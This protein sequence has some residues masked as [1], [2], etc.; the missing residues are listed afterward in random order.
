MWGAARWAKRAGGSPLEFKISF[1]R[2]LEGLTDENA[3]NRR[4]FA[5]SPLLR[6]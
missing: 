3:M 2:E 5:P 6:G 1:A 4:L